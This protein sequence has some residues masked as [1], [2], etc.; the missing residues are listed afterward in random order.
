MRRERAVLAVAAAGPRERQ[1]EVAAERD[2]AAHAPAGFYGARGPG[3]L[4]CAAHDA[5]LALLAA[6]R[7]Q[8]RRPWRGCGSRL[9]RASASARTRRWCSTS[10]PTP[11]TPGIYTRAAR[12]YDH[13]E[14][15]RLHVDR[16][17][18]VDRLDQAAGDRT[19]RTSRSWT[20]T[21]WR[22][23]ASAARTSSGSWR[24]CE[25][26]LA[27]VIAAPAIHNPRQLEGK[28]VGR[29]R[30]AQRHRG[31]ATR[32]SPAPA[33][34]PAK[35]KTITIGFNAVAGAARRPR[36]GGDR[37]LER[38]G[39]DAAAPRDPGF[40]V[41]RVEH[42]GAP[43]YPELVLCA[44]RPPAASRPGLAHAVVRT[45]VRGYGVTLTDPQRQRGRS[46]VAGPGSRSDAGGRPSWRDAPAFRAPTAT[47]ASSTS[48]RCSA[49]A[50]G[51][52]G[53]GSSGAARTSFRRSIR[54]RRRNRVL[55][56]ARSQP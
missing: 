3:A 17:L 1:R 41:F 24:S 8:R 7:S 10:P 52:R 31:A 25:R 29:D 4:S 30:R 21:T 36:R 6:D 11:S 20:S 56:A 22:S 23:P 50:A 32:S 48:R 2:A 16:P 18:G 44:T 14:G 27:A 42:Y 13:A 39:R 33:A 40:H 49:W 55:S 19:R 34:I 9:E 12:G 53:S 47:S 35:V 28:T 26:P 45:L 46:R 38:R 54:V 37:V 5:P 51:R 43:A 15:V